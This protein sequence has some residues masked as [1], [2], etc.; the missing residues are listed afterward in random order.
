MSEL[1][2]SLRFPGESESY[3]RARNELL[4]D[5]AALRAHIEAVAAKRRTLP[6]GGAVPTDYAFDEIGPGGDG[7][8]TK[9]SDLFAPAKDTLVIYNMMFGPD[10][11]AA[12][13][14]CTS[15]VDGLDSQAIHLGQQ[16]N[17]AVVARSPLRRIMDHAI[18][19]GWR[20]IRL[21]S[22][23]GNS[24][25]LDYHGESAEG[26]QQPMLNVFVKRDGKVFHTYA[27]EM[28]NVPNEKGMDP[29]HVD[30]IWPLWNVLDFTPH[31]RGKGWYPKL[32]Y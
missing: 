21:L 28:M 20:N 13:P 14:L 7:F 1:Q 32:A 29:R 24:Y 31:G 11:E 12:C 4:A 16:V 2:S 25:N 10:M 18:S 17:L 3:R 19:R 26:D 6:V 23:A 27:T 15:I 9:L 22:S 30:I 8:K 5:E